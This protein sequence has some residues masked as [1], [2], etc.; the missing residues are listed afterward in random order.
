MVITC[1]LTETVVS[2]TVTGAVGQI[3]GVVLLND[4]VG[5]AEGNDEETPVPAGGV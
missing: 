5:L 3:D 1:V 4:G 2:V